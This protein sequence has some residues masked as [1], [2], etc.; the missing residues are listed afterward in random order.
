MDSD[1]NDT[2]KQSWKVLKHAV[3]KYSQST[4]AEVAIA[5]TFFP[6]STDNDIS[7]NQSNPQTAVYGHG[8]LFHKV[9][10]SLDVTPHEEWIL[11]EKSID[12]ADV[13]NA[14]QIP[15]NRKQQ[16]PSMARWVAS[17]FRTLKLEPEPSHLSHGS[18]GS[19]CITPPS[20]Q[21]SPLH[22]GKE[23]PRSGRRKSKQKKS[24]KSILT[25]E[26]E[27]DDNLLFDNP[28][29]APS[30]DEES[31]DSDESD[32]G[33]S[34]YPSYNA[35][36]SSRMLNSA[37]H[38]QIASSLPVNI[39]LNWGHRSDVPRFRAN[40][41]PHP[42]AFNQSK[43]VT[44]APKI[45]KADKTPQLDTMMASMQALAR[46]VTDDSSLIFGDRPR[47]RTH[48]ETGMKY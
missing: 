42:P 36:P 4:G 27:L 13:Y 14:M 6:G 16:Q 1:M 25:D 34:R 37:S 33:T 5:T 7:F 19:T 43:L 15:I 3:D 24:K 48:A 11:P 45:V 30:S 39:N 41:G 29:D 18:S 38:D 10:N 31:D 47:P 17:S 32:E 23:K 44:T 12:N 46:S 20:M 22:G 2:Q 40:R 35:P 9:R 26:F 8:T 21:D 28:D